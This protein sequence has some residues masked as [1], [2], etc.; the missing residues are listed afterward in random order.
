VEFTGRFWQIYKAWAK[1]DVQ[2]SIFGSLWIKLFLAQYE[3]NYFWLVNSRS[4][5]SFASDN[6]GNDGLILCHQAL[7][8]S[9]WKGAEQLLITFA[10]I[11]H[12]QIFR[13]ALQALKSFQP[14]VND[15]SQNI[16]FTLISRNPVI[17]SSLSV[18]HSCHSPIQFL[19]VAVISNQPAH[20]SSRLWKHIL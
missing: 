16:S 15:Q 8:H 6:H 12:S 5:N 2:M 17:I 20:S 14:P 19:R 10:V 18:M 7:A 1:M 9:I 4:S 13:A 3:L 11:F